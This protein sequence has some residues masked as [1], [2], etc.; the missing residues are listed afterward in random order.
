MSVQ[1]AKAVWKG[2]LKEGSGNVELESKV[3]E[4]PYTFASRFENAG[5]TNPEEWIAA[6]H[7]GCYT[8]FLSALLGKHNIT[9]EYLE[10]TA[11]VH[12]G[13]G[14]SITQIDLYLNAQVSQASTELLHL[15]AQE[16]KEQC[17]ISKAL[18]A[19]PVIHLTVNILSPV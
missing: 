16:A 8:M 7:A 5:G 2:S 10:T 19:V 6:A 12:L 1:S 17:P 4:G 18:A 14:P 3:Y 13:E 15:L 11:K 9:P